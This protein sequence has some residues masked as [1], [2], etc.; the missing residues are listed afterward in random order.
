MIDKGHE[1]LSIERQCKL[2]E[3]SRSSFY[4]TATEESKEHLTIIRYLDS[5]PR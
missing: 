1:S 2:M 3:V 5:L 4:Y